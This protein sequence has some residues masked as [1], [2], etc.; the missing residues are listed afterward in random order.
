MGTGFFS[1]RVNRPE[2][3][4]NHLSPSGT[5]VEDEWGFYLPVLS[6]ISRPDAYT[7]A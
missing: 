7:E 6:E 2:L 1:L 3:K 4:T 5:D